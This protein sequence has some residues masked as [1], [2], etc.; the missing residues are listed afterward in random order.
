MNIFPIFLLALIV[1][2]F[3]KCIYWTIFSAFWLIMGVIFFPIIFVALLFLFL[4]PIL[5][6]LGWL[7][8][9]TIQ[10]HYTHYHCGKK[11][12]KCSCGN[13]CKDATNEHDKDTTTEKR[14]DS[15]SNEPIDIE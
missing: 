4:A 5:C 11:N 15:V 14:D 13:S 1:V 12:H 3:G 6:L 2:F 7:F 10:Q 8:R 9:G